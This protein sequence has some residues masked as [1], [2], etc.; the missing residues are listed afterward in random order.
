MKKL[1]LAISSMAIFQAAPARADEVRAG[2]EG[3]P[4]A[5]APAQENAPALKSLDERVS[6]LE[7]QNL[8][9]RFHLG[10]YFAFRYDQIT[11]RPN[12][13]QSKDNR[14]HPFSLHL[15]LNVDVDVSEDLKFYSTLGMTKLGGVLI[16]A[17]ATAFNTAAAA[18]LSADYR[19]TSSAVYV[20]RAYL[21]YHLRLL[22]LAFSAGR[23][24][25]VYGPPTNLW[26]GEPRFGT[27]PMMC[28]NA[29]MDGVALTLSLGKYL[30]AGQHL[31]LRGVYSPLGQVDF[32]LPYKQVTSAG[33][34]YPST[35]PVGSLMVE[36]G[37][38]PKH[39][40]ESVDL[41]LEYAGSG[42]FK[43]AP[44]QAVPNAPAP[45]A[46][47]YATRLQDLTAYLE[48]GD[49]GHLGLTAAVS[50]TESFF[51]STGTMIIAATGTPI[52]AGTG[53]NRGRATLV[54]LRYRIP[55]P[56]LHRPFLGGEYLY[57]T[58]DFSVYNSVAEDLTGFYTTRGRAFHLYYTQPITDGLSLRLG[59]R[60]QNVMAV[61][62]SNSSSAGP[63]VPS[64]DRFMT[65]YANLRLDL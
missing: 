52:Q 10:G 19:R 27:Y 22:P 60:R 14:V 32:A 48:L 49:L 8:L 31:N 57:S 36:Y 25:T 61:A 59:L 9:N 1:L 53:T 50:Y 30:P 62:A 6:E 64:Q 23:L 65:Y 46:G 38:R 24:P 37:V 4:P 54:S 17:N 13:D 55:L 5:A 42:Y 40:L 58:K 28:F 18:D 7:A 35:F 39:L 41:I 45:L 26:D 63:G 29:I 33:V 44:S 11:Y 51:S 34:L 16:G 47:D 12:N 21:D 20:E 3:A 2:D 15:S 56:A 43:I